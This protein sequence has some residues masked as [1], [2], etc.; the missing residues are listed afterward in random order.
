MA[1][2]SPPDP[3]EVSIETASQAFPEAFV[4]F[5]I[6][7]SELVRNQIRFRLYRKAGTYAKGGGQ[8]RRDRLLV[9]IDGKQLVWHPAANIWVRA[10]FAFSS[11]PLDRGP[12]LW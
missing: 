4:H 5:D 11:K 8:I 3:Y 1:E 2:T 9:V 7:C 12:P 6:Q 10:S